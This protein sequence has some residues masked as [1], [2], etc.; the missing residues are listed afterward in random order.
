M[1]SSAQVDRLLTK[2][3][4]GDR[5]AQEQLVPLVYGELRRLAA[6]YLRRERPGH[7]LQPTALVHEAYIRLVGQRANWQN[8]A[9]FLGIAA[10]QMKRVLKDYARR[11]NAAKRGGAD[12][13]V[14]LDS[15]GAE[16][17]LRIKPEMNTTALSVNKALERLH[18]TYPRRAEVA[19][20]RHFGGYTED[21]IAEIL[22][23]AVETVRRDWTF[24]KAFLKAELG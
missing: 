15:S 17:A 8:R 3:T 13:K 6:G 16:R 21:E 22:G 5:T 12:K 14:P 10:E 23:L 20:L 4:K 19:Q 11:H 1:F 9:H 24:A 2:V 7:T 18:Q